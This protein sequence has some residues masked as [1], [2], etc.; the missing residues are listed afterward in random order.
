MQSGALVTSACVMLSSN[1]GAT[2]TNTQSWQQGNE[3]LNTGS[4]TEHIAIKL[5]N[6]IYVTQIVNSLKRF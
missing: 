3:S 5:Y 6:K 1:A 2:S 4:Q